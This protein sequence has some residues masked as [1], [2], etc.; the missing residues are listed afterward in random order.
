MYIYYL[1]FF[2]IIIG[3]TI[4]RHK[5]NATISGKNPF[6][7][8][9][10]SCFWFMMGMK[11]ITVGV[12]TKQYLFR[13]ENSNEAMQ[14]GFL[15]PEFGYNAVQYFLHDVC[16]FS[17]HAYCIIIYFFIVA[18][19]VY[20]ISRY[21]DDELIGVSIF[22]CLLLA[23]Y[24]SGLRQTLA[25]T[26][27][28]L[29]LHYIEKRKLLIFLLLV[30]SAFTIHN[31]AII[32]IPMYFIW[33]IRLSKK[34]AALILIIAISALLYQDYLTPII[35]YL[36]PAKY[37]DIN[38]YEGYKMNVLVL[39]S[40]IIITSFSWYFLKC[41]NEQKKISVR[42]SFFFILS[43]CYIFLIILSLNSNQIGRL[44]YYFT[45]GLMVICS[46]SCSRLI[47][48]SYEKSIGLSSKF[49]IVVLCW[50]YF[51]I[52]APGGTLEIDKYS[53]VWE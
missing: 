18:A 21:V 3:Y 41:D 50:L 13:Y 5:K 28:L 6:L 42:D 26:L 24:M 51:F 40:P 38:L 45:P 8:L 37:D 17:F 22:I 44:A 23:M 1:L 29:S 53:F 39:L 2:T 7:I 27:I 25:V 36:A 31:S 46:S 33:G 20:F 30:A 43:C 52:S 16:G 34:Q 35:S 32:F 9:V 12:D 4:L 15:N 11:N 48:S 14:Y 19:L 10:F 47:Y 49:F